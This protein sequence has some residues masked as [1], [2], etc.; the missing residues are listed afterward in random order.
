MI[1]GFYNVKKIMNIVC[2]R[3]LFANAISNVIK[4]SSP[5]AVLPVLEGVLLRTNKNS[6]ELCC[7]DLKIAIKR[8]ISANVIEE[9]EIVLSAS[10]LNNIASSVKSETI[11]IITDTNLVATIKG[12]RSK[13][14]VAGI[15][16]S[17]F[18]LLP[19]VN[20]EKAATV[21]ALEFKNNLKQS[22]FAAATSNT[23]P[24]FAGVN[25]NLKNGSI[26]FRATDSYKFIK[27]TIPATGDDFNCIISAKESSDIVKIIPDNID[28]ISLYVSTSHAV[29]IIEDYTVITRLVAG[30]FPDFKAIEERKYESEVIV[31]CKD[32]L[33]TIHRVSLVNIDRLPKP[34]IC[35]ITKKA[36]DVSTNGYLGNSEDTCDLISF[37][38]KEIT[39]GLSSKHLESIL[40]NISDENIK[41]EFSDERTPITIKPVE[42]NNFLAFMAPM[43]V[44]A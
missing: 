44:S 28:N 6:V 27:R 15:S 33:N 9:G 3:N 36:I 2:E 20:R 23:N 12:G 21:S 34:M 43:V 1:Y 35:S 40:A 32:L 4:A 29:F 18:P 14:K 31:N 19:E 17:D 7:F 26:I 38:G 8:T 13:F 41:I 25:I 22:L 39:I 11:T 30:T 24:I 10:T 42:K 37:S 5:K 16:P